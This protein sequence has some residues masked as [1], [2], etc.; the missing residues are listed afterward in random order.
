MLFVLIL[1]CTLLFGLWPPSCN[2]ASVQFL[3]DGH[4]S[5]HM[6]FI[7]ANPVF[8]CPKSPIWRFFISA[9]PTVQCS[10][11]TASYVPFNHFNNYCRLYYVILTWLSVC[12]FINPAF[13]RKI[14][15]NLFFLFFFLFFF[16]FF[17]SI[18]EV[19]TMTALEIYI[20]F[21]YLLLSFLV[22]SCERGPLWAVGSFSFLVCLSLDIDCLL[23]L[24][25]G[26]W[27]FYL[28]HVVSDIAIFVLK[29]D[30]KLQLTN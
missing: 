25:R 13:G 28:G 24:S 20:L 4:L 1:G 30:V 9:G 8:F 10:F 19:F 2:K 11:Y 6:T 27:S 7:D 15:L 22:V 17:F 3:N 18:L 21:T 5:F 16:F 12:L 14:L 29:R 26:P 23:F